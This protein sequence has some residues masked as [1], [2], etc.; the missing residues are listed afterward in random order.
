MT[1]TYYTRAQYG[2]FRHFPAD[3]AQAKQFLLLT[4]RATLQASDIEILKGWGVKFKQ[5]ADPEAK[6]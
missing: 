2:R 3:A 4:G 6:V 1:I 5:V